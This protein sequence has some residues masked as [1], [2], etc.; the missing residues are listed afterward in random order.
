MLNYNPLPAFLLKWLNKVLLSDNFRLDGLSLALNEEQ[1]WSG[2]VMMPRGI[3]H[4]C[5]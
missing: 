2:A 4:V 3:L 1:S 5:T